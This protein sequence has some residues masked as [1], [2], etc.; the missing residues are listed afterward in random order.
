MVHPGGNLVLMPVA[1]YLGYDVEPSCDERDV[2]DSG[3][4]GIVR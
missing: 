4:D 1:I 3:A 2:R